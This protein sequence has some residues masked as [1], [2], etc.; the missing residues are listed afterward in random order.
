MAEISKAI[1]KITQKGQK[2]FIRKVS[3]KLTAKNKDMV[4]TSEEL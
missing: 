1:C 4:E 2:L 3:C